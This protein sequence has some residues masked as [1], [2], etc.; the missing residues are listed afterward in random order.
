MYHTHQWKNKQKTNSNAETIP[1]FTYS[2]EHIPSWEASWFTA[3]QEIPCILWNPKVHYHVDM[4][5]PL[6]HHP[7]SDQFTPCPFTHFLKILFCIILPS[8]PGSPKWPLSLRFHHQ[9]PAY[10]S[11]LPYTWYIPHPSHCSRLYHLTNIWWVNLI[12]LQVM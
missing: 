5:Q 9:N 12:K 2:V 4:S 1:L 6:V 10:T 11:P 7:E 3:S 8:I